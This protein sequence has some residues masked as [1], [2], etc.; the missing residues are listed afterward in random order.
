MSYVFMWQYLNGNWTTGTGPT[1]LVDTSNV[2]SAPGKSYE[3]VAAVGDPITLYDTKQNLAGTIFMENGGV[4]LRLST[5]QTNEV[6][7]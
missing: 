5:N 1:F 2:L 7:Q 4:Y 3:P 6:T